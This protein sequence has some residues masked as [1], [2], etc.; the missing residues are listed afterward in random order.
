MQNNNDISLQE[1]LDQ[2]SSE[3]LRTRMMQELQKEEPDADL[4]RLSLS[5]LEDREM[6]KTNNQADPQLDEVWKTYQKRV[7]T[8]LP[9]RKRHINTRWVRWAAVAAVLALVVLPMI[10][11]RAE[12]SRLWEFWNQWKSYVVEFFSPRENVRELDRAFETDHEG[13]QQIYDEAVKLGVDDPLIP[14]WF[15]KTYILG[16][17]KLTQIPSVKGFAAELLSEEK[18]ATFNLDIYD[19]EKFHGYFRDE[20]YKHQFERDG[21][22]YRVTVNNDR[23]VA[24]WSIDN[25]EYSLSIDCSEDTLWR[26]LKSIYETENN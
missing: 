11:Q 9:K 12:A 5:I 19:K 1:M 7:R 25:V 4:V 2:L 3:E 23:W 18:T 10:P 14:R 21:A 15:E 13:M 24:I 6:G 20:E 16:E 17:V 22:Q 26:T 8:G